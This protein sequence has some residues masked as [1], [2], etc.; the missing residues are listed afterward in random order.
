MTEMIHIF[1]AADENYA[2]F[3]SLMMKSVLKHTQ[4]SVYFHVMD[5]GITQKTKKMILKDLKEYKNKKVEFICMTS[6]NLKS[7]P[8]IAH[9]STNAFSRFFI[10]SLAKK[11]E[12]VIYLDV[13]I[14]ARGD[15]LELYQESLDNYPIGAVNDFSEKVSIEILKNNI[16]P[17]FHGKNYFNSG[18]MIFDIQKLIKMDFQK[19]AIALTKRLEK[20]LVCADQDILNILF[21]ENY[22]ILDYRYNFMAEYVALLKKDN[23]K[24]MDIK[25]PV[26]IHY[27]S[28]I[29]PWKNISKRQS[30][31]D[32]VLSTSL[33]SK[34]IQQDFHVQKTMEYRLFGLFP[35]YVKRIPRKLEDDFKFN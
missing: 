20:K 31:F 34:R 5:G 25:N 35:F 16:D 6:Y 9:F 19:K 3:A 28:N 21:E 7:F 30:D 23:E 12:R 14:I 17:N 32:E 26:L 29:K 2:P 8:N 10:P 22:K 24:I 13:D 33:F 4:S 15:I 27:A 18:V 11:L 1:C